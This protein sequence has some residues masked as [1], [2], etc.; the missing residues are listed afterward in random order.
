MQF[1]QKVIENAYEVHSTR[2][3]LKL[4]F[5][6]LSGDSTLKLLYAVVP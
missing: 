2:L 6:Y 5:V 3:F 4:G 1:L